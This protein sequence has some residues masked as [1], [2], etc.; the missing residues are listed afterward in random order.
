MNNDLLPCED[1]DWDSGSI[2]YNGPLFGP[3]LDG[4]EVGSGAQIC[5]AAHMLGRVHRHRVDDQL[6][7][8]SRLAE[9][10][11]LNRTL[12]ALDSMTQAPAGAPGSGYSEN[13]IAICCSARFLLYE[14]Y[15]CN[16][17]YESFPTGQEAEIQKFSLHG[18]EEC[19]ERMYQLALRLRH[20]LSSDFQPGSPLVCH[21]LYWAASECRWYVKEGKQEAAEI[22]E[23][24]LD[25]LK[26]LTLRWR[27][28]GKVIAWRPV[29][30][31]DVKGR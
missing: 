28:A 3:S 4:V 12:M 25:A 8:S 20:D 2:S 6:D 19:V 11:Q 23:V 24:I 22:L 1:I 13:A 14:L 10:K 29:L 7:S 21:A 31:A 16:E 27:C 18:I 30:N 15:A 26:L 17:R 5:Q 9:A